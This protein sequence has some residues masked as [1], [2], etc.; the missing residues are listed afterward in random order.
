MQKY[1][2]PIAM[3]AGIVF[4]KPLSLLSPIVP[5]LLSVM[6]FVTYSRISWSDIHLTKLHYSL[7]AIQYLGS[8]A[9][10][11]LIRQFDETA[12]QAA[13][14][15]VLAPTASSAPVV[16]GLLGGS[17]ASVA[18]F[19]MISNLSVAFIAPLYLTLVGHSSADLPFIVSL[20]YILR[21]VVPILVVPFI[22]TILLR[23][24][25]PKWHKKIRSTQILSFYLWAVALTIVCGNVANFVIAYNKGNYFLEIFISI[26][27]LI[28]CL[29]QFWIGRKI[30]S[31]FNRTVAGGQ[32]LGQKNT[33]LAIWLTQTY[34]NPIASLD[35][36]LYVV[37][38]N[39]VNSW[40]IW[41]NKQINQ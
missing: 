16:A 11:L 41:R 29:L 14:I 5:Y 25:S 20:W 21:K 39:S 33:V 27:S 23:K 13:M 12:A 8:A 35:P 18:A 7:L 19:S 31:K 28:I 10:Y 2:L 37:W 1:M 4:H 22:L 17:I 9:V 34:L 15:C 40:Q 24:V 3:V 6:L 32:S 30:G 26:V 38:Q 36:G